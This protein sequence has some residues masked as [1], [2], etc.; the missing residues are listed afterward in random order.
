LLEIYVQPGSVDEMRRFF[1][2]ECPFVQALRCACVDFG[3]VIEP[4]AFLGSGATS[5][6]FRATCGSE[7]VAVKVAC[8]SHEVLLLNDEFAKFQALRYV[9]YVCRFAVL[10]L[11][12]NDAL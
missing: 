1:D 9:I 12:N 7:V 2:R 10:P 5:C 4:G 3:L 11:I 8:G 6:V